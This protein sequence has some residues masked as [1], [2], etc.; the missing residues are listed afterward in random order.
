MIIGAAKCGTTSLHSYLQGHPEVY[1]PD[2]KEP[3]YFAQPWPQQEGLPET[4]EEYLDL[5]RD[6]ADMAAV[7][8]ASAN[9]LFVPE[10]PQ[11]IYDL[12]GANVKLI[13]I[14]RNPINMMFSL[15]EHAFCGYNERRDARE[16]LLASSLDEILTEEERKLLGTRLYG[17]R[18]N[19][20]QQLE[21]YFKLFPQENIKIF[22]FE[23]FF[24]PGLPQYG[25][26]CRFLG[27]SEDHRPVAKIQNKGVGVRLRGVIDFFRYYYPKY[28]FP[29]LKHLVPHVVRRNVKEM[30]LSAAKKRENRKH[31]PVRREL[32]SR[33]NDS[34][35]E[36][37]KFL[38]RDLSEI[39]F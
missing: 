38:G 27:V 5:F 21:R 39:W 11:R 9:Y 33:L 16:A 29:V 8:E 1:M 37:E 17:L 19:Y 26:L 35:R 23:E 20:V 10:A 7:G 28:V 34:V 22:F 36:L 15:W 25:E 3:C 32:E 6:G 24:K 13:V 12:L 30:I 31:A 14:L 2:L 18:A 4:E